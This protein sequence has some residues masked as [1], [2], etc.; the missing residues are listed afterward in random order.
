MSP[1]AGKAVVAES[2]SAPTA[3]STP[4][5]ERT[6]ERRQELVGVA[7]RLF[8]E[9]G[10]HGTSM[11][12]IAREFGVRKATLY[13]WVESKEAL[14]ALVLSDAAGE[15]ASEMTEI[16]KAD[17][18]ASERMRLLIR[19]HIDSWV[20]NPHN[21]RVA[22]LDAQWLQGESRVRWFTSRTII[23]EAYKQV[24]LEGLESG[25]LDLRPADVTLLALSILGL[26]NS[27]PRWYRP[28]NWATPDHISGMMADLVLRGLLRRNRK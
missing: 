5:E 12:D 19:V 4:A 17:L 13:H 3:A 1:K 22:M 27:F 11:V 18:P 24:L 9:N 23:E 15:T 10:F 7:A 6:A 28:A 25:E 8:A 21:Q 14:L 2:E 20:R 16:V 26:V